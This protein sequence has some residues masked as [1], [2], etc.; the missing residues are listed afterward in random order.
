MQYE[1]N[2]NSLKFLLPRMIPLIFGIKT[3]NSM[4][5]ISKNNRDKEGRSKVGSLSHKVENYS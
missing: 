1:N 3:N 4:V 5:I 2:K